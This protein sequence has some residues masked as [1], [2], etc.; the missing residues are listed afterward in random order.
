V[1]TVSQ[2]LRASVDAFAGYAA[3]MVATGVDSQLNGA[4]P[5]TVFA[6]GFVSPLPALD[7]AGVRRHARTGRL[8]G[9]DFFAQG[10]PRAM[11]SLAGTALTLRSGS[12]PTVSGPSTTASVVD[13]DFWGSNGVIH[14]IN[15]VL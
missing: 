13:V 8:D 14:T 15:G 6:P 7:A 9:D 10:S 2:M 12:P 1:L 4:G 11:T 3:R 5:F